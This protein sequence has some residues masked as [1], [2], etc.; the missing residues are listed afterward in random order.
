MTRQRRIVSKTKYKKKEIWSLHTHFTTRRN[1]WGDK[2]R[3]DYKVVLDKALDSMKV[4]YPITTGKAV[5]I[6]QRCTE[7]PFMFAYARTL[8]KE[9]EGV[10]HIHKGTGSVPRVTP[11]L[12]RSIS[13]HRNGL[14]HLL[15]TACHQFESKW[16]EHVSLT[17]KEKEKVDKIVELMAD[18][19]DSHEWNGAT[20]VIKKEQR[21]KL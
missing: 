2:E 13:Q 10:I 7:E 11:T 16:A 4:A 6:G 8:V 19:I 9:L 14:R 1:E 21:E 12:E 17:E 5:V 18:L 3:N 20:E 15:W